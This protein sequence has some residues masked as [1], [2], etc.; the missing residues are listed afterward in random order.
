MDFDPKEQ[1]M[2]PSRSTCFALMRHMQMP[3]HIRMHSL[4]VAEIALFLTRSL[5]GDGVRLDLQLVEAAALLHDIAKDQSLRTGERHNR[6][7]AHMLSRLGYPAV[8]Q[9]VGDH[10]ELDSLCLVGP[11]TE[12]IIVNYSDKRVKHDRIVT[13]HERF[14]DL[15][16]RYARTPEHGLLLLEKRDLYLELER[17]IF[18]KLPIGPTSDEIMHL[19]H[20]TALRAE[21]LLCSFDP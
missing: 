4:V 3:P 1:N 21:S 18:E 5:S 19:P 17:K 16:A 12:S 15:V 13:L 14:R 11:I 9:I 10:V 2:I 20:N 8:A 6:L 7:G